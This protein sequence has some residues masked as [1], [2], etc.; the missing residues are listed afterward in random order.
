MGAYLRPLVS[1]HLIM[2]IFKQRKKD[3]GEIEKFV[4]YNQ[5]NF[6]VGIVYNTV[7]L[8]LCLCRLYL[9]IIVHGRTC[10]R[11]YVCLYDNT[12]VPW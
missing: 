7:C 3:I 5:K 4:K 1:W 8:C 9:S 6:Y 12:Y 11:W 10:E 2:T